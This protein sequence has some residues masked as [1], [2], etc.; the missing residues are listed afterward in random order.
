MDKIKCI[1]CNSSSCGQICTGKGYACPSCLLKRIES[2]EAE[3]K[4]LRSSLERIR[5]SEEGARDMYE[6]AVEALGVQE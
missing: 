1:Y 2:L 3:D 6:T 4:R 5:D